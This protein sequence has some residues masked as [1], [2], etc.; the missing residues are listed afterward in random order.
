MQALAAVL[1]G[2]DYF[3]PTT[4]RD[5]VNRPI[6]IYISGVR[7]NTSNHIMSLY[8]FAMA[9][10]SKTVYPAIYV[11]SFTTIL[12]HFGQPAP[13]HMLSKLAVSAGALINLIAVMLVC[14]YLLS[15][16][17]VLLVVAVPLGFLCMFLERSEKGPLAAVGFTVLLI[18][19]CVRYVQ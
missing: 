2:S 10:K 6:R 13:G 15:E 4:V 5:R 1:M 18:S 11:T 8:R 3:M 9:N 19:L 12:L 16:L 17:V 14:R 7:V